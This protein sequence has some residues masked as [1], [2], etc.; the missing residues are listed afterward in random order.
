[1][2]SENCEE[3]I[4]CDELIHV[5][6]ALGRWEVVAGGTGRS[7]WPVCLHDILPQKTEQKQNTN[8]KEKPT[9]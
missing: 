2:S 3:Y 4:T 5:I 6:P 8:N 7:S 1:M 9:H